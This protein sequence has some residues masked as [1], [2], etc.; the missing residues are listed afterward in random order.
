MHGD[1][2]IKIK[3]TADIRQQSLPDSF[4]SM[5]GEFPVGAR[6]FCRLVFSAAAV[7]VLF[8]SPAMAQQEWR[9]GLSLFGALKYPGGFKQ[10]DYVNAQAPRGGA[11]R[12][13]AFGTF[14][15][16]NMVVAGVKGSLAAGLVADV[17]I[18]DTLMVSFAG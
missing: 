17:L 18:Y 8:G 12:L 13:S 10:F 4:I 7:L 16:F 14:D 2:A 1:A 6:Q 11:A 5:I 15:N 9:H 3:N